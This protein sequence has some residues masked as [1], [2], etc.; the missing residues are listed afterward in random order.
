L[1]IIWGQAGPGALGLVATR[2]AIPL[3]AVY[4]LVMQNQLSVTVVWALARLRSAVLVEDSVYEAVVRRMVRRPVSVDVVLLVV[5][6][7]LDFVLYGPINA[8]LPLGGPL[9]TAPGPWEVGYIFSASVLIGWLG[10]S[11]LYTAVRHS[12][13]FGRLA[14]MPLVVN[15]YDPGNLLPFGSQSLLHSFIVAGVIVI[16]T[17]LLGRPESPQVSC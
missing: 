10:L 7:A 2:L 5:V 3:L 17:V 15:V 16:P 11:L 9:S 4:M 14:K 12:G 8:P 1:E 6:L 13:G